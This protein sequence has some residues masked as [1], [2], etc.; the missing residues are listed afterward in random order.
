[1]SRTP[2]FDRDEII[3]KAMEVF[4]NKG[5]ENTSM[6][7]LMDATGL[8][9]GSLYNTFGSKEKLF[10]LCLEKYSVYSRGLFY[11][12][13]DPKEY[14]VKFF[15]R[16]V[17]EGVKKDFT[18]GCLI[19]NSCLEFMGKNALG[20]KA[21]DMFAATELNLANVAKA[22]AEENSSLEVDKVKTNLISAAFSIREISKFRKDR[23]FLKQIANN[24][25]R[26]FDL[27]I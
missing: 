9:K 11:K 25:L 17:D 2:D 8:L 7:D 24:A 10:M 19:M 22:I 27:M 23:K 20:E 16:L 12:K 3:G 18:K 13:G 14:L 1:M 15:K 6:R 5:Y 26:D 4:W 21:S